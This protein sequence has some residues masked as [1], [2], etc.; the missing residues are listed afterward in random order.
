MDEGQH[1]KVIKQLRVLNVY[2]F[3]HPAKAPN[4]GVPLLTTTIN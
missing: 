4:C 1:W 2:P 3:E